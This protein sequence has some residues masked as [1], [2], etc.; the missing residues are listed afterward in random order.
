MNCSLKFKVLN[1][2]RGWGECVGFSINTGHLGYYHILGDFL[3]FLA[4]YRRQI[5]NYS[6][7]LRF[8]FDKNLKQCTYGV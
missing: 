7:I 3:Y 1:L 6:K 5:N 4:K 2:R 8:I